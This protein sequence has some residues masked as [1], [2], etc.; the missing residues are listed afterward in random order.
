MIEQDTPMMKQYKKIKEKH[1]DA[2]L[3]FRCGDF[4]EMFGNDAVEA[5]SILDITLTKRGDIPMC[6]VPYHSVDAYIAKMIKSGNKIAICEQL[7][8][9]KLVKGIVKRDVTQVI[10]PGTLVE[11]N[12]LSNKSNN[13]LFALNIKGLYIEISY[14]DLS[15]GDFEINEI[16]YSG[17]LSLLKGELIRINPKEIL[18]PENI[19]SNNKNIRELF[20]EH[21]HI[22]I[23]RFPCW[24]F[25]DSENQKNI[26]KHFK[27]SSFKEINIRNPK[28][29]LTTPG[30]ILRYVM[31]NAKSLLDHIRTLN[32]YNSNETMILDETT[33]KNLEI[34]RNLRDDSSVNTLLEILD[35]TISSMGGRLLKKWIINPLINIGEIIKRQKAVS[36]FY[37]NQNILNKVDKALRNVMDLE[38][39][40]ARIVMNK[41]TP[42]DL[43]SIKLS[44][45]GSNE[46]YDILKDYPELKEYFLS[47]NY[48]T[49]IINY[50]DNSIKDE[51]SSLI[52][53]GN[54]VKDGY[55][56]KLDELKEISLKSKEYILKIEKQ[57]KEK[58]NCPSLKIKY[59]RVIGYFFEVSK[60]Q[61][62][63]LDDSFILRQSL[64]NTHRYTSPELSSYESKVLTARD[65]IN[66]IEEEIFYEVKSKVLEKINEIQDNAKMI[67]RIDVFAAFAKTAIN[68]HY[69]CPEVNQGN[70]ISIKEGRHPVIE[71][72][73]DLGDF[74]PND[75]E[76]DT[77]KDYLLIITGPNMS[78][79][80]TY[81]RQNALI[82]LMTQ[83][84][85]Y[86]PAQRAEIGIVDRIFTR[87]GTSDN[88]ARG[89]STFL[90]EMIETANILKNAT[91]RSFIIMDEI[92]RGTSTFDG[93]SIAWSVL[94][95]IH[96]KKVLGAKTLFA[97]HYH[98]LTKLSRK[99]GIK[100]YS[101]AISEKNEEITFLHKIIEGPSEKSYG[102]H[103]A[104]LANLPEEVI[105][106][107]EGLLKKLEENNNNKNNLTSLIENSQM[108]LFNFS[109]VK[110][111]RKQNNLIDKI[112][113]L[114]IE[115]LT[116]LEAINILADLQKNIMNSN[117]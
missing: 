84:G 8:D 76:I 18:I 53:E 46:V 63:N 23:N 95:Y 88:L 29:D 4:Y 113:Y 89:Q 13:F 91:E 59:N 39:L 85:S 90:V 45:T 110:E 19:W 65:E 87:I 30:A 20:E 48:L 35:K 115:K 92:G 50:I 75:L 32:Y 61:S 68:N 36:L 104:N 43:V 111:K 31:D 62:K 78:G 108:E 114:N 66:K 117:N 107:S 64:V 100:N 37:N 72:K 1:P 99:N 42:K 2:F 77:D 21:E 70:K 67:A 102:I 22:L 60:L 80:S 56:K 24:Y 81:L 44:L 79:K 94:E 58:F 41:A 51:P 98:E 55:L 74:I 3:F 93:L 34:L 7:E 105:I 6:G 16:E 112:K 25:E 52:N 106:Y 54:I 40:V 11:E 103:V 10:T 116:P 57:T 28:T 86:V 71:Q 73:L 82:V 109:D 83:I 5:S 47:Y 17:D 49:E 33:I 26:L 69:T 27:I 97:T 101:I 96:N 15:T 38:R 9:P 12:I 14:L